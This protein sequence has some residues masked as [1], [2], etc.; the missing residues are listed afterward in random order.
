MKRSVVLVCMFGAAGCGPP[1]ESP[2]NIVLISIDTLRHD[3]L[4]VTGAPQGVSPRLDRLARSGVV[5]TDALSTTSWTLPSHVSLLTGQYPPSHGVIRDDRSLPAEKETLA[6][7][8]RDRGYHTGGFWAGPYLYPAYGFAQGFDEYAECVN[9][10]IKLNEKGRVTNTGHA[11]MR[12]RSG[13][14]G[15]KTHAKAAAWLDSVPAGEPWFLFLHYWDP[16]TDYEAPSPWDRFLDRGYEGRI[17]GRGIMLDERIHAGMPPEDLEQLLNLYRSEIRWTDDWIGRMLDLVDARG[18]LDDAIVIVVADHG[19][20]FFEHGRHG[21]RLNLYDET[22]RVPLLIRAPESFAGGGVR[23]EPVS[24]VDVFPTV[25]ALLGVETAGAWQGVDLASAPAAGRPIFAEMH[26]E[27]DV[28]RRGGWKSIRHRETG[29]GELYLLTEDP[30]E[31]RD[32][33]AERDAVWQR[34]ERA[35]VEED[36]GRLAGGES[37]VPQID[38][39]TAAELKALGYTD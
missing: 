30:G 5:F 39:E 35:L 34:L 21:H 38:S 17:D 31:T 4:G 1:A 20:E 14:T 13:V 29:D 37:G 32:V 3:F 2:P 7:F 12:S 33:R 36:P 18:E 28:V 26:G 27:Q 23:A 10:R 6:E 16:H 9:Y 24:L 19:E 15:P 11:N 8:L 22:L 25:A